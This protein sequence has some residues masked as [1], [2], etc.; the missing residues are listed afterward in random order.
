MELDG[1]GR[2]WLKGLA[3][4]EYHLTFQ[5]TTS[6]NAADLPTADFVVKAGITTP[7]EI[8]LRAK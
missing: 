2:G 7:V 5:W 6:A 1:E 3:A 4:G 8:V